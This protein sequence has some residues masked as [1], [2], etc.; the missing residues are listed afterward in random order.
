M[1]NISNK[2]DNKRII[3]GVVVGSSMAGT[4]KVRVDKLERHPVYKKVVKRKKVF[5]ARTSEELNIG[6][7]VIIRESRPLSKMIRW[8]VV[9]KK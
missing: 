9:S 4:V 7:E 5:F 3:E 1:E 6:D 8:V 2:K